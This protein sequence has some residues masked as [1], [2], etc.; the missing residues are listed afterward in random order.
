MKLLIKQNKKICELWDGE[1]KIFEGGRVKAKQL[2]KS[3]QA[4][5]GCEVYNVKRGG[6]LVLVP[7]GSR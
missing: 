2:A 4:Q 5:T 3:L 6:D 1:K 7:V